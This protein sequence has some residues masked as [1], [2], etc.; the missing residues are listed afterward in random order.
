MQ[1]LKKIIIGLIVF[2]SYI[3]Y[4]MSQTHVDSLR[5]ILDKKNIPDSTLVKTALQLCQAVVNTENA[6]LLPEYATKGL[7]ADT[8]NEDIQSKLSLHGLLGNYYWQ[9]G[10]LSEAADQFNKMRVI[11]ESSTD[12]NIMANSLLGL[13]TVY[14]QI[15]DFDNALKFYRNSLVLAGTD[16]LLMARLHNNL[17]NTFLMKEEM[18]SVLSYYNLAIAYHEKHQNYRH[19]SI[20]YGNLALVHL[21]TKNV[22]K[23]KHNINQA[24]E[25][26]KKTEDPYQI[27][28]IYQLMGDLAIEGHPAVAVQSYQ[29]A[30]ALARQV[31][32]YEQMRKNLE[33]LSYLAEQT[34]NYRLALNYL[35]EVKQLDDS[36]NLEQK[37]FRIERLEYEY[38]AEILNNAELKRVQQQELE[39]LKEQ[40]RQKTLLLIV[41]IAFVA[42]LLLLAMSFQTYR[43]KIKITKSKERFFSMIAHDIRNP[44]SGILGLSGL[45]NEDAQ[46]SED[47]GFRKKMG[48]LD[49]SLNQVYELLENLLQWSQ[50]ETGKIAFNPQV[51]LLSPFVHEVICLHNASGKQKNIRLE[52]QI[53]SGLTARFDSNMLQVVIR[54]LLSNAIKFS[55]E[56]TSI[57]VSATVQ[58]KEVVVKVTDQGI[59]MTADQLNKLFKENESSSTL[60]TRNETGTGLGIILCKS[61]ISR[62]GGKIW[63][64]SKIGEG[65]TVYFTLPD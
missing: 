64:E 23:I 45:L 7:E 21:R 37:R 4:G 8:L 19:L 59:G 28:S 57:F 65:T 27:A 56:G 61:F 25:A 3:S 60:G 33:N 26:A 6:F 30:L 12:K 51:Q 43:L 5:R 62:H 32:S 49:K 55:S 1:G 18:D 50:S 54:N 31:K 22:P 10:K 41:T 9:I 34:G 11:G 29:N 46:Q 38:Q 63:A 44:F 15:S 14:Y 58:S 48:S 52:N 53:Q 36:M 2:I 17:A 47:L 39:S 13:G 42:L 20:C 24:L 16:S 35:Q 40:N